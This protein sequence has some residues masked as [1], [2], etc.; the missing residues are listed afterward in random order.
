MKQAGYSETDIRAMT[1]GLPEGQPRHQGHRRLRGLRGAARQDRRG[2]A[3]RHLRRRPH[4]RHLAGRVRQQAH[5]RGRDQQVA[6]RPGSSRCSAARSRRRSTT[7]ATTA[8]RGSWTRS[9]CS[10]T[11]PT[12]P[13]PRSTRRQLDD[14]GRR[15]QG[16]PGHQVR[17]AWPST[18]WCGSWQQAEALICD[19]AQL[20]GAFGGT[21]LD[22]A[23]K[24]AFQH[25]GGVQALEFMRKS[26]V[27]GLDRPDVDPVPGGG[28]A[29]GLLGRAGS[30]ALNW[31][32]MYGLANDPK[33][34]QVGG[35]VKRAA[36]A[37]RAR[38]AGPGVNGGMALA[39]SAQQQEP[40][41]GVEV[42]HATSPASRCRRSTRSAR[43]RSGRRRTTTRRWS[44]RTRRW[45]PRPR[46]SSAT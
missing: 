16:G 27:D 19:Y 29:P 7:Q 13:R 28:R 22:A 5:R 39:V 31:T 30:M 23:G 8:C 15:A 34:S 3:G 45:C 43:C 26:I 21:F 35:K 4:R 42:H 24:P 33:Q 37:R 10:S 40:G 25:G 38:A 2:G 41:R 1:S 14:L 44:R 9:T 46:S 36:D 6:G 32:Y 12:W 18:R 17:R 11:P 20:L